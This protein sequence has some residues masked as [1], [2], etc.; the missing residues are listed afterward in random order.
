MTIDYTPPPKLLRV[1]PDAIAAID[2]GEIESSLIHYVFDHR[3]SGEAELEAIS[4]LPEALQAWYIAFV[5]DAEV[6]NGGFNQLFFNPSGE[7]TPA[8]PAAFEFMAMPKAAALI[9]RALEL[10]DQHAPALEAAHASGTLEA[11][12]ETYL[13]QPFSVL[14]EEYCSH[15]EDFRNARVRFIRDNANGLRHG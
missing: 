12:M 11:F 9:S 2:D 4:D 5:V 13:D 3:T 8:A 15:E 10:L 6:L 7:L 1:T 14:D